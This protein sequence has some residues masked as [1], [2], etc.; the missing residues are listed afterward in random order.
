MS[1]RRYRVPPSV[2]AEVI[3]EDVLVF[4]SDKSEAIRLSG[5]VAQNFL[6]IYA[7]RQADLSE[8]AV[9]E[10]VSAGIVQE[11]VVSRRGLVK[12]GTL[13]IGAGISVLAMPSVARAS[14]SPGTDLTS[15]Q[16]YFKIS[17]PLTQLRTNPDTSTNEVFGLLL[18][19][20]GRY[21]QADERQSDLG[22]PDG[23]A[24][25][26]TLQGVDPGLSVQFGNASDSL[27]V[28]EEGFFVV[29]N[30]AFPY[31]DYAEKGG[32]LVHTLEFVVGGKTYSGLV[33]VTDTGGSGGFSSVGGEARPQ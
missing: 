4:V 1:S 10:L 30:P 15:F 18:R 11:R 22:I 8:S 26:F 14:S 12:A 3:G 6:A 32:V 21:N 25:T 27:G 17:I 20:E 29:P 19:I 31:A 13:G 7:G 9:E 33:T 24:G 23:T 16:G 2:F 5:V 28:D